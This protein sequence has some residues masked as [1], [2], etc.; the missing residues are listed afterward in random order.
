MNTTIKKALAVFVV[1]PQVHLLDFGGPA[2]VFYE[3]IEE[4]APLTL[5]FISIHSR[6]AEITSSCG[7]R[8][9]HLSDFNQISL[10]KGDIVF[11]PGLEFALL[12]DTHFFSLAKD[13]L[14]WIREQYANGATICSVCTGAFLLAE[15]G[16]L[17][18]RGCTTHWKYIKQFQQ[19]YKNI[20]VINNRLFVENDDLFT[21]A[22]VA[23]GIDLA[24]YIL[25]KWYGSL[26]ASKIAR[27]IVIYFRREANDPQLSIFLQY[28]NHLDD[29]IHTVQEWLMHHFHEKFTM[30]RLAEKVNT[31]SRHLARR[32]KEIT[33]ITIGQYLE[34]L[35]IEHALKLL[36]ENN[37]V[38]MIAN[39]CG[40]QSTNQLRQLFKKHTGMLPSTY[41][42][43]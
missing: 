29:R 37:K 11:I 3:A 23:S 40:F 19:R 26:F 18:G 33:G 5:E 28:R 27:E 21:S 10:K 4:G 22:G 20:N 7:V 42:L 34:K 25:E 24:L 6:H 12:N 39:E 9:S 16:L 13:F 15:A 41:M 38:E 31:S 8:F 43:S 2:Q 14:E 32:F 1:P 17:D 35:R 30:E 36:K